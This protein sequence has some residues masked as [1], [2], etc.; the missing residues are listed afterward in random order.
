M[1][2]S[3]LLEKKHYSHYNEN[4]FSTTKQSLFSEDSMKKNLHPK[5]NCFSARCVCGETFETCSTKESIVVTF[6]SKCHPFYT[7]KQQF[8]DVE[9]RIDKFFKK[10]GKLSQ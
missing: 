3:I 4:I 2:Y 8:A 10:Y 7:N 5:N 6:C 9:G 1:K